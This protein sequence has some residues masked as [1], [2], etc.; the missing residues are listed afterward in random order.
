MEQLISTLIN[1]LNKRNMKGFFV[2]T[3]EELLLLL[4]ELIL[5]GSVV[6]CGD[7]VTFETVGVT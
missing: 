3:Q 6:G 5:C 7:S 2:N 4:K 1:N